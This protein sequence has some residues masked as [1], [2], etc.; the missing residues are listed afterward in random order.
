MQLKP[1]SL[2]MVRKVQGTGG[3]SGPAQAFKP[4]GHGALR[5]IAQA[6]AFKPLDDLAEICGAHCSCGNGVAAPSGIKVEQGLD[7]APGVFRSMV[8][9]EMLVLQGTGDKVVLELAVAHFVVDD[10]Y[11]GECQLRG[12]RAGPAVD[13]NHNKTAQDEGD[14]IVLLEN[15]LSIEQQKHRVMAGASAADSRNRGPN[16]VDDGTNSR[17]RMLQLLV[18]SALGDR[19]TIPNSRC[20]K[21]PSMF[22][23]PRSPHWCGV[24]VAERGRGAR[25][26]AHA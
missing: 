12:E 23:P 16:Q 9:R 18:L 13:A 4:L 3:L 7:A 15:L 8:N 11:P 20:S 24:Q 19:G 25:G 17:T 5:R 1:A 22:T 10:K 6:Q 21:P 14:R 26:R 2:Q